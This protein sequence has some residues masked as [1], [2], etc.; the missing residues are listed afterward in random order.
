MEEARLE[1]QHGP[2][3]YHSIWKNIEN[4]FTEE[5]VQEVREH[6]ERLRKEG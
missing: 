5:K 4:L 6:L 1:M 3:G 2:Y